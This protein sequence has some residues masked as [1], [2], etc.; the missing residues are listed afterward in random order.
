MT[1]FSLDFFSKTNCEVGGGGI[2]AKV[3][4]T[5][6]G[7]PG[8]RATFLCMPS[9]SW[10]RTVTIDL[11]SAGMWG[12]VFCFFTS[13]TDHRPLFLLNR[14][15]YLQNNKNAL[16]SV[17][18]GD[19]NAKFVRIIPLYLTSYKLENEQKNALQTRSACT[20]FLHVNIEDSS[21]CAGYP[22]LKWV[23]KI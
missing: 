19:S 21:N 12:Y 5:S 13:V 7:S 2:D 8:F 18:T 22:S 11:I 10:R 3:L 16:T 20:K 23:H 15:W 6:L 9:V 14:R 17:D 4:D 1:F